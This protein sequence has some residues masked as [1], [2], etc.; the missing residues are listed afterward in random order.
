MSEVK[1]LTAIAETV[2]RYVQGMVWGD[3]ELLRKAFHPRARCIGHFDDGL[4]WASL[5][6]FIAS[7]SGEEAAPGDQPYWQINGI[8]I[9]GDT[10]VVRVEN[11]WAGMRFD[12]TLTLLH[13]DG[14][15][16]IVAKVFW[17]R[18]D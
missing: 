14:R 15:W 3:G 11:N 5:E 6:E 8:D 16:Q 1:N 2:R 18:P 12:D 9:T 4:E 13:H 7:V 17:L 10:A